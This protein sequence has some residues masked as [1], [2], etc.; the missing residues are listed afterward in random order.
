MAAPLPTKPAAP[1]DA[2]TASSVLELINGTPLVRLNKVPQS[3]GITAQVYAKVELFNAGGSVKDRIALR[4]IEEAEKSGR[5]KPGDTLIEPTSG[6]TGIGLA[7]VGAVKGYKT[8]ITLPE[9]MSA[10]KVSVLRALGATIIRTPTQAA[11]DSPESHIGVA[12]RL[13]KEI[14]NSHILDQY[15]N[16]DNPRAHEFGTAEEIWAQTNGK[17]T[18]VVAGAGT[19]GTI[20]G[21]AKGLHKHNPNIKIIGADPVGSIL[22][23]PASLNEEGSNTPYKVEGIGYDFVPDVLDRQAVDKWYKTEDRESFQLA[24]RLIAEEGLLVGGSSGSAMAAMVRAVKDLALG[25]EDVV[26]VVL[27]DS[28]R[29]Y[30]SKFA[31]DDWL[32]ANDLLP[33]TE[34]G[35]EAEQAHQAHQEKRQKLSEPSKRRPSNPYG[36]D[37][38]RQLR[39]KPVTSVLADSP[40]KDAIETMR[41]KGFD[42]LPV[43]TPKGDRLAGLVTLGNLLSYTSRGRITP[44]SPVSAAMFDFG[45]L[46]EVVTDPRDILVDTSGTKADRRKGKRGFVEITMDTPLS[47]LSRFLEWNSAAIVTERSGDARTAKPVAV[48]TKVDLL[49][50]M[51]KELKN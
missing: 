5:I 10:E 3:L 49:T 20:S 8:I 30:L 48:V 34:N 32:A 6:N 26:V 16:V 22:A 44:T 24:R 50:W 25:P 27:P 1:A 38:V 23:E 7:L 41:D 46:D 19:G 37:T 39:L 21:I 33:V 28:I 40:C 45:R 17:I 2:R 51:M 29:S 18:A 12:L 9:K 43:L 36:T 15:T 47:V 11:W 4:M 14:P 13:Q 42:Q 31:D 35:A